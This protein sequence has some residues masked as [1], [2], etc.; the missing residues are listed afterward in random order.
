MKEIDE[1]TENL[2]GGLK[3]EQPFRV[4]ENYFETF[5]D[6]LKAR[7]EEEE[8]PAESRT[9]FFYLRPVLMMAASILLVM[10][11]VSVPIK[12]FLNSKKGYIAKNQ[13]NSD[14]TDSLGAV[15]ANFISYFSEG[16]F[17]AA[18]NEMNE[19]ETD[20]ISSDK[21]ADFIASNYNDFEIISNN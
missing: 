4:P 10:L 15:S 18:F 20:T 13:T 6:R 8:Q 12:N 2:F 7:I 19:I 3:K 1:N 5:A 21:L 9:V 17:M 11:L 14:V 16:Q